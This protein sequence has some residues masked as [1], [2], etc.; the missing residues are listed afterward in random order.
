MLASMLLACAV[1]SAGQYQ[2]PS[3]QA[4]NSPVYYTPAPTAVAAPM[5]AV[6]I[7]APP[8]WDRCLAKTGAWLSSRA[9]LH[10]H[11]VTA[12]LYIAPPRLATTCTTAVPVPAAVPLA[13][14]QAPVWRTEAEAVPPP[15]APQSTLPPTAP[16]ST[17]PPPASLTPEQKLSEIRRL[18]LGP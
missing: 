3:A 5:P 12:M 10:Q 16:T 15:P 4:V 1:A 7:S 18:L 8:F 9:A 6:L 13:S 2:Y 11:P 17:L 14:S